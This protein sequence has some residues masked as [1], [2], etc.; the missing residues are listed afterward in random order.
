MKTISQKTRRR[1]EIQR[2]VN[3][4]DK[5]ITKRSV[6]LKL[7]LLC[8][9][10]LTVFPM[11][12]RAQENVQPKI[13]QAASAFELQTLKRDT[14]ALANLRGKFVVIHFAASW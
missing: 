7:F 2:F 9:F 3:L 6:G 13:G 14:I 1:L 10:V 11:T 5:T 4:D 8:L 12:G